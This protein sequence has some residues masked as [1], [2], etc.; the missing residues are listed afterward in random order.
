MVS[1]NAIENQKHVFLFFFK[2]LEP[3]L[4]PTTDENL[5][6]KSTKTND[7]MPVVIVLV[8]TALQ[9]LK[10]QFMKVGDC[11]GHVRSTAVMKFVT[12]LQNRR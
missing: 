6:P 3:L 9:A 7:F 1:N 2:S 10:R 11:R 12:S 4:G 5:F 8:N